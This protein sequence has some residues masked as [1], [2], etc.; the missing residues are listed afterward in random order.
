MDEACIFCGQQGVHLTA[1]EKMRAS[2]RPRAQVGVLPSQ[3]MLV[4]RPVV[5][6]AFLGLKVTLRAPTVSVRY[7]QSGLFRNSVAGTN[8]VLWFVR[9]PEVSR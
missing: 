8:A 6:I 1:R 3:R 5:C 9:L 4:M 2:R 7:S